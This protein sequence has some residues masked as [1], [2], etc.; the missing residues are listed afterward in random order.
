VAAQCLLQNVSFS[1][2]R[3]VPISCKHGVY[4]ITASTA[5]GLEKREG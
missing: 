3:M 2:L 5:R 4:F 1:E